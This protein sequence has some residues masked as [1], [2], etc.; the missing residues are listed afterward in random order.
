VAAAAGT[1]PNQHLNP[2]YATVC[3]ICA[4]PIPQQEAFTAPRP[5]LGVLTLST[6]DTVPLDRDVVLGRAPFHADKNA[7]SRPH[8]VRLASPGNDISR[9][10]VRI[11]LEGWHVQVTDLGSTNGTVVTLPGQAPVRLRAHDPFTIIPG[12][13][14]NI[15]D[16]V[17]VR[18]EVPA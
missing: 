18:F 2:P 17:H 15:A 10:H 16:E 3:R 1:C 8:L 7:Q 14:V 9:S 11:S 12:T 4:S 5:T 6:G 13:T